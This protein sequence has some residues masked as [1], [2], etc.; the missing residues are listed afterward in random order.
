MRPYIDGSQAVYRVSLSFR[1]PQ[2]NRFKLIDEVSIYF[3]H[4]KWG[5]SVIYKSWDYGINGFGMVTHR[6]C[7]DT[8]LWFTQ[9]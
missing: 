2:L 6:S 8:T 5:L 7:V 4:C 9:Y 3:I 1:G